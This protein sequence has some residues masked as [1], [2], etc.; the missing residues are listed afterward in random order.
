MRTT[1]QGKILCGEII[2]KAALPSSTW[3]REKDYKALIYKTNSINSSLIFTAKGE[4][5]GRRR[6]RQALYNAE[7]SKMIIQT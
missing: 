5:G 1:D 6:I 4:R 7:S 3:R 2:L